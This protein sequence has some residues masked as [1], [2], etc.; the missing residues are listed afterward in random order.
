MANKWLVQSL[1]KMADLRNGKG[2]DNTLYKETGLFP[3]WGAN[4]QINRTDQVLNDHPVIVVGRVGAYCGSVHIVFEPNWVTDNAIIVSPKE[5]IDIRFLYYLL[6]YL[7]PE[8]TAIGSAQPLITQAGLKTLKH[9][10]PSYPEQ[11]AIAHIL[12]TLDDK[13]E[14]NRQMNETLEGIARAIFKSWFVD[15]DPVHAKAQG[16]DTGLPSEISDLFPDS[17]EDSPLGPIPKGWKVKMLEEVCKR[18]TDG[19]H[20]SP[21]SQ[22]NGYPMASVK[23]MDTWGINITSCRKISKEEYEKLAR[24][25]CKPLK[26]DILIA[27]DGSY[28]K[29]SFVIN[30]EIELVILSSIAIL[31]PNQKVLPQILSLILKEKSIISR[32][33][34]FV[35]GAVLQRVVLKDFRKFK[36]I[37]PPIHLQSEWFNITKEIFSIIDVNNDETGVLNSIRN[38]L[39]PKLISGEIKINDADKFL[40]NN[41]L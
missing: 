13:I 6:T 34:N 40:R 17:F 27:K 2:L 20:Y 19:S 12:G 4:G 36:I 14:L 21:K 3:V 22:A 10:L 11:R 39:L 16:R 33:K 7:K 28:L 35:S 23:D 25:D 38:N 31:R 1:D 29:H 8:R 24:N 26:N 18:I 30:R 37:L 32:M 5:N 41:D 15:F 9:E